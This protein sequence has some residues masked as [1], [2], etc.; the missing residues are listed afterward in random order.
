MAIES[1][2]CLQ[3]RRLTRHARNARMPFEIFFEG[4]AFPYTERIASVTACNVTSGCVG[5]RFRGSVMDGASW[6]E[7]EHLGGQRS[8]LQGAVRNKLR[9]GERAH[10]LI[11]AIVLIVIV[12]VAI[13]LLVFATLALVGLN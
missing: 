13:G 7:L 1:R 8:S 2:A 12:A 5:G 6:K 3:D 10:R 9:M 11:K 4:T